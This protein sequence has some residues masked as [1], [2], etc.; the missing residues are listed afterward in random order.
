MKTG[1]GSAARATG[2]TVAIAV[3]VPATPAW[4]ND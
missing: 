3:T 4:R 2:Y 1:T